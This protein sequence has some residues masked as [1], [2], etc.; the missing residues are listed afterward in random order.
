M[1]NG[2]GTL[3]PVPGI[4]NDALVSPVPSFA[5]VPMPSQA[6]A[7]IDHLGP[8]LHVTT[9]CPVEDSIPSTCSCD[10][11][12]MVLVCFP[13]PFESIGLCLSLCLLT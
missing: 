2:A 6:P 10:H 8:V 5:V 1:F 12:T 7:A 11:E 3:P 13:N 4:I 9:V